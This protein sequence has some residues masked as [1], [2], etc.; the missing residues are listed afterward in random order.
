MSLIVS[1]LQR[2]IRDRRAGGRTCLEPLK[3]D[4]RPGLGRG[5]II[6]RTAQHRT[7]HG[8]TI[9]RTGPQGHRATGTTL[10]TTHKGNGTRTS[11]ARRER[12]WMDGWMDGWMGDQ[13][14]PCHLFSFRCHAAIAA[15]HPSSISMFG[16][17]AFLHL[18]TNI[19]TLLLGTPFGYHSELPSYPS[20]DIPCPAAVSEGGTSRTDTVV[21]APCQ[22]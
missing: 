18:P 15:S 21:L 13:K 19:R 17:L 4:D 9:L 10:R 16:I 3:D 1:T 2:T 8:R 6:H 11:Q 7:G 22:W 14:A 12:T 20:S 5:R